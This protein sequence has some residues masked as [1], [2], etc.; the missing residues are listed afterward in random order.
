MLVRVLY[1]GYLLGRRVTAWLQRRF[2]PAGGFVLVGL[3]LTATASDPEHTLGWQA[4]VV[5]AAMLG[6][7]VLMTP[8]FRGKFAVQRHGPRFATAG[9]PF[10]LRIRVANLSGR[11][12]RGLEYLEDLREA[13]VSLAEFRARLQPGRRTRSF[14][15]S[16]P[17]PPVRRAQTRAEPL[18]PMPAG[19]HAEVR[20]DVL[21]HRRGPLV[22]AGGL[23]GRPDPLGLLRSFCRA[24]LPQTVLVLPRRFPLAP[25]PMP[26]Q[27][28]YQRGGVALAAG[29]GESEE[30]VALRDYRRG[31]S[32]RRVHWR[33]TARLGRPIVKEYQDEHFIRH[34]LVLDTFCEAADDA[35]F[36]EAVAVAASFA[37]TVP[38]QDSLLDLLF[39]GPHTV[40]VT[41]GR[42]VGHE[43]QMLEVLAAVKPCRESKLEALRSLVMQ[44]HEALSG[45]V[46][47]FLDWDEPRRQVVRQLRMVRVPT[48]V[49]VIVP[50]RTAETFDRGPAGD[51]PDRLLVLESGRVG[52]GLQQLG[53][54]R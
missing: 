9:E 28:Q 20:I 22:L 25:P 12:Q 34:A 35:R 45:C 17:L 41:T 48:L 23:I 33:T 24:P 49:M 15:L 31:D 21:P 52:E 53:D 16:G 54:R 36:E 50:P 40:C 4:F 3:A 2:T 29:V 1:R 6:M 27:S 39:V 42:G 26:G 10:S 43:Q 5:L 13:D 19:S 8:F 11:P 38:D 32:L 30:F 46:L 51:Q 37:C 44:H 14:R 47:V 7:A 18:P